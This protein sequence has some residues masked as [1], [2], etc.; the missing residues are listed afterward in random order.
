MIPLPPKRL[1]L[2]LTCAA[3]LWIAACDLTGFRFL[4]P[5][6]GQL[7]LAGEILELE[8]ALPSSADPGSLA[9]HTLVLGERRPVTPDSVAI[10]GGRARATLSGLAEGRHVLLA[11]VDV[12]LPVPLTLEA[13]TWVE[14]VALQ[15]P[16]ACENLNGI[17][18]L[19]PFPSARFLEPAA[20]ATGFRVRYPAVGMPAVPTP[21]TP[22]RFEGN[23]GFSPMVQILT[24]FPGGVDPELSG[25]SRLLE[26]TRSYGT[27]SL[28]PDSPTLL[29]DVDAGMQPVLHFIER[30]FRAVEGGL[31]REVLYLRPG[32]SLTPG[33]RYVVA[34]R[35]LVHPDGTPVE[36][37]PV[38]AALRD[39]RP[40]A[41][42]AVEAR[43]A[44]VLE[45]FGLL[46]DAGVAR[47]ELVLAF[48]FVVQSD[49]DLADAMLA[50]R[51]RAFAWLAAAE[52]PTF[53]VL[54]FGEESQEFDCDLPDAVTWREIHGRFDV[55]LFLSGDPLLEAALPG[56]L[57][58]DDGDGLP[59]PQG[60]MQAN[61]SIALPCALLEEDAEPL[62]PLLLGHGLFGNGRGL[63]GTA[64]GIS[65]NLR[66]RGLGS[67]DKVAGA[68]DFLGLSGFDFSLAEPSFVVNL[69]ASLDDFGAMAD[70]LRQGM[71]NT[72]V[73]ARMLKQGHFNS[74]PAFQTPGGMPALAGPDADLGYLGI[75]LGGIMGI[76]FAAFSP[77]VANLAVDIPGAN[78]SLMVQRSAAIGL[79]QTLVNGVNDDPMTQALMWGLLG[80]LWARGE[81]AG[82]LTHVTRDP[83][84]GSGAPKQLLMTVARYDGIVPNEA[85]EIAA[86]TLG[87]P[88]LRGEA[89]PSGSAVAELPL[90]PDVAGPLGPE[91]EGFVGAQVWYDLAMYDLE[92][93]DVLRFVPPLTNSPP[94]PGDGGP[95][96]IVSA[97]EPHGRSFQTVAEQLQIARWLQAPDEVDATLPG[98]AGRIANTCHGLCDGFTPAGAPNPSELDNDRP[99]PCDPLA[100]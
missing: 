59:D 4:T 91:Q 24:H 53:E 90:V 1:A 17:E 49:A 42:P 25:A 50:M 65:G 80:E 28:E 76:Y 15:N 36:A 81:P 51:D 44:H 55:P 77:D 100:E 47:P 86:R 46:A 35:N 56:R 19:L 89:P 22:S 6:W 73:L 95:F 27:R 66:D 20:T 33:H 75:S 87:L 38:F 37:E 57:V 99:T 45:L 39:G 7:S 43:R 78:F 48:D 9:F 74:H 14:L 5:G 96:D 69:I 82:Y 23:D 94:L 30:D 61:F 93:P 97:C 12:T 16:D 29:F 26:E 11:T 2:L 62:P 84:P 70:R 92:N 3:S 52:E 18:C 98:E 54:P 68:T 58:D 83:L 31:E 13:L 34:M 79:I 40:T 71:T 41:I 21:L 67:F 88:N 64:G 85:S 63:V 10:E 60:T 72:L 32:E 8:L